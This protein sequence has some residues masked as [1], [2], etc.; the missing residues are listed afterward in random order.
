MKLN[1]LSISLRNG[2]SLKTD[3]ALI[4]F[5]STI[6]LLI[7]LIL[8]DDYETNLHAEADPGFLNRGG[9]KDYV[10]AAHI[11]S[12]KREV[13]YGWCPR[14]WKLYGFRCSLM[15]SEPLIVW[16]ILIQNY[17]N[18]INNNMVDQ[19]LERAHACCAPSWIRHCHACHINFVWTIEW[20]ITWK[21]RKRN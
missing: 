10:Q 7:L 19:N 5:C 18:W 14:P 15:L 1:L 13:H 9:A 3:S 6:V 4:F 16:I 2:I 12:A 21:C 20:K 8:W 17:S 11:P